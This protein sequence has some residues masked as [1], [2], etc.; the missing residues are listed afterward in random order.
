M[1]E[2]APEVWECSVKYSSN[3]EPE[4]GDWKWEFDT[5]GATQKITQSKQ[6]VGN[7]APAGKT[8]PDFK[9]AIGVT[10]D[11]V[12][13]CEIIVPQFKWS[14]TH[15][16]DADVVTWA[17]SQVLYQMTGKTNLGAFRGFAANQVLFHGAKGSQSGKNPDLVELTYSFAAGL[18]AA[19]L[20]VGDI[21][22]ISKKAWEY[23]WVRYGTVDDYNAKKL[24]KRPTSVHVERVYDGAD[25][26]GLADR[27]LNASWLTT[28]TSSARFSPA[29]AACC[30]PTCGTRCWKRSSMSRAYG[31]AAGH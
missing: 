29:S 24:V 27:E 14:E 9:G 11:S 18:H 22:G 19:A 2:V 13:G 17:Y 15:Q 28:A 21:N 1:K 8:A 16:L 20:V 23:L 7:Y 4:K 3:K 25:F 31:I 30:P 6:N 26:A 5:T 12:E 10:D